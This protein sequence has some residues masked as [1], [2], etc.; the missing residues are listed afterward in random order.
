MAGVIFALDLADVN[1]LD[2]AS[3]GG[4]PAEDRVREA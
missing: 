3:V 4:S 1:L 2:F